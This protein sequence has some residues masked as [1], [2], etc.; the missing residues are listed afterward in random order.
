M[1]YRQ[2]VT[3]AKCSPGAVATEIRDLKAQK[4]KEA[5]DASEPI[6]IQEAAA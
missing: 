5:E 6:G 4:I 3:I 1:I 2:I